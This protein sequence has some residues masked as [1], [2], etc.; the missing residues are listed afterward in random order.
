MPPA[1]APLRHKSKGVTG[2]PLSCAGGSMCFQQGE[3][4]R[5]LGDWARKQANPYFLNPRLKSSSHTDQNAQ[6]K[7]GKAQTDSSNKR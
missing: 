7:V 2:D 6:A 1:H 4:L 5:K 3:I